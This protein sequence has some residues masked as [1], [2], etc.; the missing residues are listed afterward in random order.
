MYFFLL[1]QYSQYI[2]PLLLLP[3]IAPGPVVQGCLIAYFIDKLMC[4]NDVIRKYVWS[5]QIYL[6]LVETK[7]FCN[8]WGRSKML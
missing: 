4:M 6:R 3:S 8:Q 1:Q 5:R 2:L 7:E